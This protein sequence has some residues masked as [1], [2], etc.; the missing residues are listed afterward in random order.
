MTVKLLY[1]PL[2]DRDIDELAAVLHTPAVYE[3]I[4]GMPSR[5]DFELWLRRAM[6]GPPTKTT[7]E[8]WINVAVRIAETGQII[9]RLEATVH[10]Q[11]AEVAFLY[12]PALWGRG[13]ASR[14][15]L[16]LHDHLRQYE[17]VRSLWATARPE[18]HRSASLLRRCGYTPASSQALPV[19]Y[20]YDEGDLVFWRD[21]GRAV[22]R[23]E[24]TVDPSQA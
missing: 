1:S 4:G 19:L 10:H 11:L 14:G 3:Y 6:A 17:S 8:T 18:N 20:S 13:Y 23:P 5:A 24:I 15:L 2:E 22:E 7:G 12:S 9:G 16:W 21:V